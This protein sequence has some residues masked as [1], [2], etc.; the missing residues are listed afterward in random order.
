LRLNTADGL[1]SGVFESF[2]I[3]VSIENSV[4]SLNEC[5]TVLSKLADDICLLGMSFFDTASGYIRSSTGEITFEFFKTRKVNNIFYHYKQTSGITTLA[6][7]DED[8]RE[9]INLIY[10]VSP[11]LPPNPLFNRE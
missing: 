8:Q 10:A 6:A 11:T 4:N 7:R 1:S 2:V 3:P 5:F 9:L